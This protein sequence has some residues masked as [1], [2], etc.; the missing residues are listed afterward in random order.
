MLMN[1]K[2]QFFSS[3]FRIYKCSS[4][5]EPVS[6]CDSS[7]KIEYEI[8]VQTALTMFFQKKYFR[9]KKLSFKLNHQ[10]GQKFHVSQQILD[11]ILNF[12]LILQW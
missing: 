10:T 12:F 3:D 5:V 4:F 2:T 1:N 7:E 8:L 11:P 9:F 6:I